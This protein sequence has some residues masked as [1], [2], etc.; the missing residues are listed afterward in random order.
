M[1]TLTLRIPYSD[2]RLTNMQ[3]KK[4][5]KKKKKWEERSG[6]RSSHFTSGKMSFVLPAGRV[7]QI[8]VIFCFDGG[9]RA[10]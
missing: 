1:V 7:R 3:K 8:F 2:D 5:K 10:F 6:M 9:P 4:K